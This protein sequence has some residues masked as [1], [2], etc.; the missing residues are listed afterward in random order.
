MSAS[1]DTRRVYA[2]ER[3]TL[4]EMYPALFARRSLIWLQTVSDEVW[5]SDGRKNTYPPD[6]SVSSRSGFSYC[7]GYRT[8][9]LTV[10][11]KCL[12][13][14]LHEITHA[15]GYRT[16]DRAF[17][18]KYVHLLTTYGGCDEGELVLGLSTY[19]VKV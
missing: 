5:L 12:A 14:L 3:I 10:G 18:K 4:P 11:D 9:V 2:F 6:V 16:H 19:G 17:V 1:V 13:I 15:I 8:I 7:I